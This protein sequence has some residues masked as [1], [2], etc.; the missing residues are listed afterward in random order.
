M[1]SGM[2]EFTSLVIILAVGI[3]IIKFI[4][5]EDSNGTLGPRKTTH[6][7]RPCNKDQNI[8]NN[9]RQSSKLNKNTSYKSQSPF[10]IFCR[11][12]TSTDR[13][14]ERIIA[15]FQ[16]YLKPYTYEILQKI[17]WFHS[18]QKIIENLSSCLKKYEEDSVTEFL[19]PILNDLILLY[20]L[21]T[22]DRAVYFLTAKS[23]HQK[24]DPNS[25]AFSE[26]L[27][28]L[29]GEIVHILERYQV[30]LMR[31]TTKKFNPKKQKVIQIIKIT[32][33]SEEG[34]V[35]KVLRKGFY[36]LGKVLRYEEVVVKRYE[37]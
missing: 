23:K 2:C 32:N 15:I 31:D 28:G 18:Q 9:T 29:E 16:K 4:T 37:P 33:V 8:P 3:Q 13:K 6:S 1:N 36:Y 19:K 14:V 17:R 5:K 35:I 30:F 11:N 10:P 21:V 25:K 22:K 27:S 12:N 26:M 24:N 7:I 20:D 34:E